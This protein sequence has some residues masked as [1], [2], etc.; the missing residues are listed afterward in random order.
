[1]HVLL[2]TPP[3]RQ[4]SHESLVVPPLGLAY[5]AAVLRQAGFQVMI[6]DA[7]A[8]NMTWSALAQFLAKQRPDVLALSS[9]SPTFDL[10]LKTVK[11]ARP[12]VKTIIMGGPHISVWGQKVFDDCPELD[13]GVIGEGE[14]TIV[15]LLTALA[16]NA[17]PECVAGV[18][19]RDFIGP[20]RSL[21]ADLDTLPMPA[22]DLL[23]LHLYKYPLAKKRLVTTLFTSRGCPYHCI[24]CDKSIF[25]S[26]WRA[27]SADNVLREIDEIVQRYHITSL[28]I[29]DDLFTLD[30]RRV[31]AICE[32][33]LQRGYAIDWKCEGRVNL[34]D[35]ATLKLMKRAGCSLIAYGVESGT[36]KGLD[37]LNKKTTLA[38]IRHAFR[39]TQEAG[40]DT[41]AYFIFGIPV[42]TYAEEF[43]TIR[44]AQELNPTYAQFS[45]LSPYYGTPLYTLTQEQGWYRE[46][47]AKNPA[48]KDL[49]RPVVVSPLWDE[50]KLQ[51]IIRQAHLRFYLRPGYILQR[52]LQIKTLPQFVNSL[53]G[54]LT[55]GRWLLNSQR[56]K[57][58]SEVKI[59]AG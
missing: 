43:Q 58:K 41:M 28:I 24:F 37:F 21:I 18:I 44:F 51:Q 16:N 6:K 3:P 29:Y 23:P 35:P 50:A 1:M 49:R 46:L 7:F 15:E 8:E 52:L 59:T 54:F 14:E 57:A 38:Q 25:G 9:M 12:Y 48:D 5:L 39:L 22:R 4:N 31:Q 36:Q 47:A 26:T 10:T 42:E 27:R 11:I 53:K 55:L 56:E 13:F 2:M 30:K 19:G 40:I 32:G 33:I 45:T 17:S 20:T 34:V